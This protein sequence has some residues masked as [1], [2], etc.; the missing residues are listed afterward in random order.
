MADPDQRNA[1][2]VE[3]SSTARRDCHRLPVS[4]LCSSVSVLT[5][6]WEEFG[7]GHLAI[8]LSLSLVKT[9]PQ[10]LPIKPGGMYRVPRMLEV[11]N[12]ALVLILWGLCSATPDMFRSPE[13]VRK[14]AKLM[15]EECPS[16][17]FSTLAGFTNF[18]QSVKPK[19]HNLIMEFNRKSYENFNKYPQ[20]KPD[21]WNG[22][23][24]WMSG[25]P[26]QWN[27]SRDWML[28]LLS[29]SDTM[30]NYHSIHMYVIFLWAF[31][32]DP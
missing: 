1:Y 14:V 18:C 23:G 2:K 11:K 15:A 6:A 8:V 21:R 13:M 7:A 17:D 28:I 32:V 26:Q 20:G 5:P 12:L 19:L 3:R 31:T 30:N 25:K 24:Y 10:G 29:S 27:A 9:I 22:M 4:T 16:S